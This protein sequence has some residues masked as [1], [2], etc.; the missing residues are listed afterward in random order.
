MP[1][2]LTRNTDEGLRLMLTDGTTATVWYEGRAAGGEAKLR[3]DA[4]HAVEIMRVAADGSIQQ[5]RNDSPHVR[6]V[7]CRPTPNAVPADRRQK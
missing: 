5:R 7:G 4:P 1:L 3:V 6:G 2:A